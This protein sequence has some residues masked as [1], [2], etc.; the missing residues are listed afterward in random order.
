MS[1]ARIK[2]V[3]IKSVT[4]TSRINIYL[5]KECNK[6][7]FRYLNL[8]AWGKRILGPIQ[9]KNLMLSDSFPSIEAMAV[10]LILPAHHDRTSGDRLTVLDLSALA[11][12]EVS[13]IDQD[14]AIG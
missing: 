14:G 7:S 4:G 1:I 9:L 13:G 8:K 11:S 12:R 10:V 3:F 6:S 5:G 2:L